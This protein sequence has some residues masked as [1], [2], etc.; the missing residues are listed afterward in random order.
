M[1]HDGAPGA[2][3]RVSQWLPREVLSNSI[4][5]AWEPELAVHNPDASACFA[6]ALLHQRT[7]PSNNVPDDA[8]QE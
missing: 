4:G 8:S 6:E 5:K 2:G 3:G 1:G 7:E